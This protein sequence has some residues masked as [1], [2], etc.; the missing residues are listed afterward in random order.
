VT[1]PLKNICENANTLALGG[2]GTF[3]KE[4]LLELNWINLE[5]RKKFFGV[6][7]TM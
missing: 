7:Q 6:L 4:K 3:A 1:N 2:V 5:K